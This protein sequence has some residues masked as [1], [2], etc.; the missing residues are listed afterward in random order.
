MAN[1]GSAD[2]VFARNHDVAPGAFHVRS[3]RNTATSR[4][5]RSPIRPYVSPGEFADEESKVD[6]EVP[7]SV[8]AGS[9]LYTVEAQRVPDGNEDGTVMVVVEARFV[10]RMKWYQRRWII[11]ALACGF[12]G[13]VVVIVVLVVRPP[14]AASTSSSFTSPP[15][16]PIT[17]AP[18]TPELTAAPPTPVPSEDAPSTPEPTTAPPTTAPITTAPA[19]PDP[20]R[21]PPTFAPLAP[22]TPTLK[23]ISTA[24]PTQAPTMRRPTTT[25]KPTSLTP[26]AIACSFL[27]I[28]NVTKCRSTLVFD[29]YNNGDL[30]NRKIPTGSTIPSE[31]G[32]LTQLT[33]LEFFNNSLTSAIPSEIGLLTQLTELS[34]HMNSLTSTIPTEIGRLTQLTI[35]SFSAN[36]LT[37]TIPSEIGLL[38]RLVGLSFWVNSF[39]ST[40]PSEIGLLTQLTILDFG[41]QFVDFHHSQ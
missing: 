7:S 34:F 29:S 16:V 25:S 17:G 37:F 27:S 15:T 5:F 20:T 18:S 31:I 6:D 21:P 41:N 26:V 19:T 13:A 1:W 14:S 39:T 10:S 28:P 35:L 36:S 24:Q 30:E 22:I 2:D 40:I 11:A 4:T 32:H 9:D 33:F 3:S 12:V 23:P 38:S 8:A